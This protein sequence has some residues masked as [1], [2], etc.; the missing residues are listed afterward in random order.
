MSNIV[1]KSLGRY[2]IL[3]Q[4]GE[5]GM[6]T[7]FK[8]YDTNLERDVAIKVIRTELFGSAVLE[9]IMQRFTR[10]ARALAKLTHAN[11]VHVYDHG[12]FEGSPYL[13][14]QYVPGGTMKQWM[15]KP[16]PWQDA[17]R[18]LLPIARALAYAHNRGIVHRDI[19]PSNILINEDHEPVLTDF[20][21]AKILE[22][23][24]G[25]TLTGTGVGIGTPEYMAPEQGMGKDVDGRADI[26]ALGIVL[27]ELI[28]GRKPYIADTPMAVVFKHMTD[29]LPRPQQFV[30]NLP[31]AVEHILIKALAKQ[32]GDRYPDMNTFAGALELL[33]SDK[34]VG[35]STDLPSSMQR[36]GVQKNPVVIADQPTVDEITTSNPVDGTVVQPASSQSVSHPREQNRMPLGLFSIIGVVVLIGL[37]WWGISSINSSDPP[38]S[39]SPTLPIPTVQETSSGSAPVLSNATDCASE[40]VFCVGLVTDVGG[41][42]DSSFN[43]VSW[44]GVQRAEKELGAK[45]EYIE[46]LDANDYSANIKVLAEKGYD[47]I[48]TVNYTM[49]DATRAAAILYPD[50]DF[51]GVDQFQDGTVEG[52]AGLNF[53]EDQG[54]FLVGALASMMSETHTVGAVCGP[55]TIPPVWRFGTGYMAGAVYA[56]SLT[57]NSTDVLV[58]YHNE[59]GLD[60]AFI[61]PEWGAQTAQD[62]IDQGVDVIFGCGGPTGNGALSAAAQAG[63]YVIGVDTDQYLTL[64]DAAPRMLS[65][66]LKLVTPGVFGLIQLSKYNNF[67]SGN[68]YGQAGYASY[69]DLYN[70][71][72]PDVKAAMEEINAGLLDG[73]IKTNVPPVK[74]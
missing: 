9:R 70:E 29:P 40:D 35:Q 28:T 8:A 74:P 69:H 48:V 31:E 3:E 52:V 25:A 12:E 39:P 73:S 6:A 50:V 51:I 1:G 42:N 20:G 66:A 72:P 30:P 10:E 27:Y 55:D 68:Y 47:V 33:I 24:D 43:Q 65:S 36:K 2:H 49:N 13:V 59:V 14:M 17:V 64:P 67:P 60:K 16:I 32:A 18:L 46:S 15:G 71:V 21:I 11:I 45:I 62:L 22:S 54:G 57:G 23:E 37:S 53:P 38:V 26:Y 5:G 19:K 44:E 7:V 58:A 56:D 63:I 34:T 61:D 41:I 4:L